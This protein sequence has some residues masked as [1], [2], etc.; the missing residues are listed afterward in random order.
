MKNLS[1]QFV[2]EISG[3]LR[4]PV[5][6]QANR[7]I[8]DAALFLVVLSLSYLLFGME[9]VSLPKYGTARNK[10]VFF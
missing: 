7:I 3:S 2:I 5:W 8:P 1:F 4:M 9:R 10:A 6:K